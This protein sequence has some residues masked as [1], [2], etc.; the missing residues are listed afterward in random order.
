MKNLKGVSVAL[1]LAVA[2]CSSG[3]PDCSSSDVEAFFQEE[4]VNVELDN[5]LERAKAYME[6]TANTNRFEAPI[7]KAQLK[8]VEERGPYLRKGFTL[9]NTHATQVDKDL[10][11]YLCE[12]TALLGNGF[13][14]HAS[15]DIEYKIYTVEGGESDF[16]VEYDDVFKQLVRKALYQ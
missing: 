9:K 8:A 14:G 4:V 6:Q 10:D 12:G 13:G 3:T 2:G 15:V 11:I 1:L 16:G 7:A 5:A